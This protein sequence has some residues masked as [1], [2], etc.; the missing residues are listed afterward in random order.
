MSEKLNNVCENYGFDDN[1]KGLLESVEL[2]YNLTL[3]AEDGDGLDMVDWILNYI[4]ELE[5]LNCLSDKE[6]FMFGL[7]SLMD[8]IM[9]Y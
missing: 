1:L 9:S 5:E 7:S 8:I 6:K 2:Q 3:K 4:N